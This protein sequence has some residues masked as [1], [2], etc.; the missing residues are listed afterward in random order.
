MEINNIILELLSRIQMLENKVSAL[1]LQVGQIQAQ[2]PT[3]MFNRPAFPTAEI[4]RKYKPLAE[5]LY[6]KWE[7]KIQVS[8]EKIEEILGF[9]LPETAYNFPQSYWAN[10][11]T[12]SY[13]SSWL[14]IGYKA[15]VDV[16]NKIVT[17]EKDLY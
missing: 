16:E 4:S 7:K 11:Q 3:T 9:S 14:A 5:Y 2:A 6:E 13:A 15:K 12:H 17:F 8:Y 10:T 1:E